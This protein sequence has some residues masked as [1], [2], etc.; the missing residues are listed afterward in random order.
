MDWSRAGKHSLD[1]SFRGYEHPSSYLRSGGGGYGVPASYRQQFVGGGL[2]DYQN[3]YN[4]DA[5]DYTDDSDDD[6][7]YDQIINQRSRN[8]NREE[9]DEAFIRQG[10]FYP[11]YQSSNRMRSDDEGSDDGGVA[12]IPSRRRGPQHHTEQTD[13]NYRNAGRGNE[14]DKAENIESSQARQAIHHSR[15]AANAAGAAAASGKTKTAARQKTQ[16]QQLKPCKPAV[17]V[18]LDV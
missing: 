17:M 6:E 15:P 3:P 7:F 13:S 12:T 10:A 16:K 4:Y 2:S 8:R 11:N 1:S 9:E 5:V 14:R 18:M